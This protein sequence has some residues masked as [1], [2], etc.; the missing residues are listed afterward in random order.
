[1]SEVGNLFVALSEFEVETFFE[2]LF[3]NFEGGSIKLKHL[4]NLSNHL[5]FIAVFLIFVFKK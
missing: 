1:M 3:Y 5:E 2:A 4:K